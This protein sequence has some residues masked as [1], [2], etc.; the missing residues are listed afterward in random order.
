MNLQKVTALTLGAA[1]S[2]GSAAFVTLANKS[3]KKTTGE[4][5][6]AEVTKV[7]D[8]ILYSESTGNTFT[9][10]LSLSWEE[11]GVHYFATVND[12][13]FNH[14]LG[15]TILVARSA[16]NNDDVVLVKSANRVKGLE[17]MSGVLAAAGA[18]SLVAA[19]KN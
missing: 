18:L 6:S 4:S 3:R 16:E 2:T 12:A 19:A 10:S 7:N 17:L 13:E 5:F 11:D 14:E 15:D 1:L 9:R 8:T